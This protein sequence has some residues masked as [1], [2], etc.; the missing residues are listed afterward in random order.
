VITCAFKTAP[1]KSLILTSNLF[2]LDLRVVEIAAHRLL[3]CSNEIVLA[4][5]SR[6]SIAEWLPFLKSSNKIVPTLR[7]HLKAH[8]PWSLSFTGSTLPPVQVALNACT[9]ATLKIYVYVFCKNRIYLK[10]LVPSVAAGAII[11]KGGETIT[12]VQKEVNAPI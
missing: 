10:V 7:P 5:S 9:A 2:P 3:S 11:G 12:E 4:E 6:A 1:T 8:P